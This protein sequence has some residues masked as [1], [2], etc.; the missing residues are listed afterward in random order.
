[1]KTSTVA[2]VRRSFPNLTREQWK[3]L[4]HAFRWGR[5][6]MTERETLAWIAHAHGN[7]DRL[8]LLAVTG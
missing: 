2:A 6:R 4:W 8:L 5:A 3:N 1:M 7:G